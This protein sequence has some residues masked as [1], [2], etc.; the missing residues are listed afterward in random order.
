MTSSALRTHADE[1]VAQ[2]IRRVEEE[3]RK[4]PLSAWQTLA[5]GFDAALRGAAPGSRGELWRL[6]G[7]LLRSLRRLEPAVRAYRRA[8]RWYRQA[9]ALREIGRCSIG[10][11]DAL[12]YMGRYREAERVA[13]QGRRALVGAGD[14]ASAARLLNN[15]GNLYHRTDRP[16]LALERYRR[17]RRALGRVG[18]RRGQAL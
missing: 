9:G 6:R 17:A 8:E 3:R 5:R 16:A 11:V 14:P 7:H 18:D 12:M 1:A 15:E 2:L 10:L 13:A 4:Q